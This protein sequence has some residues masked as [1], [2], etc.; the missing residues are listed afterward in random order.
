MSINII[1]KFNIRP[2]PLLNFP[3]ICGTI[4]PIVR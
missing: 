2:R 3:D 4:D 1:V